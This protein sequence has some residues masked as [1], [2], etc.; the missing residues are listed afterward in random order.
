MN[1]YQLWTD[2]SSGRSLFRSLWA[3]LLPCRMWVDIG[4][5]TMTGYAFAFYLRWLT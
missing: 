5:S 4:I 1:L 2:W 3:L